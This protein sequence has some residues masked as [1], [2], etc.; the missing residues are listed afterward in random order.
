MPI[1]CALLLTARKIPTYIFHTGHIS[2]TQNPNTNE[3][4]TQKPIS[5]KT[6][7]K[8]AKVTMTKI[9]AQTKRD[10]CLAEESNLEF[11]LVE[12]SRGVLPLH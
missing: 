8:A 3:N 9:R 6:P 2:E 7:N 4:E 10:E 12:E 1:H 11:P 5:C